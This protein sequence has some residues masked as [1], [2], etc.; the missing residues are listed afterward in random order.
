MDSSYSLLND[1]GNIGEYRIITDLNV[2]LHEV[3]KYSRHAAVGNESWNNGDMLIGIFHY[4]TVEDL[5]IRKRHIGARCNH[6][7]AVFNHGAYLL[8]GY[9]AGGCCRN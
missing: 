2:W 5:F 6:L 9:Q 1:L 7:Q 3:G 8:L 4:R